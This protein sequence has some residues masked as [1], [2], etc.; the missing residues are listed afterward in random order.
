MS[1]LYSRGRLITLF[2]VFCI[3]ATW[4]FVVIA[5]PSFG[6]GDGSTAAALADSRAG[7]I[8]LAGYLAGTLALVAGVLPRLPARVIAL[9]PLA[10]VANAAVGQV[11]GSIGIPLYLDSVGTVLIAALTGPA[12]GLTTGAVSSVAWGLVNPT[13]LPFAAVSAATGAM[14]GLAVERGA[15]KSP[16][17]MV[18]AGAVIGIVSGMLAAP[19]AAFVYGGTSGVGTGALV[20]VF[21]EVTGS[22]I[23]SVTLQ[24]AVSDPADK[25]AVLFIVWATLKALPTRALSRDASAASYRPGA[26]PATDRL[27]RFT[28]PVPAE[29]GG[30]PALTVS[31]RGSLRPLAVLA[32]AAIAWGVVFTA[33]S[34][35]VSLL[36]VAVALVVC[37][38]ASRRLHLAAASVAVS[39]P[40]ALSVAI[41]HAP[42]GDH[43]IG[44]GV[45][46]DGLMTA[47]GLSARC[48]ALASCVL[49]ASACIRPA[50]LAKSIERV[51]GTSPAGTSPTARRLAYLAGVAI[52]VIPQTGR[53]VAV[54]RDAN[55]L[56]GVRAN[57]RTIVPHFA[58]PVMSRLLGSGAQRGRALAA[59]GFDDSAAVSSSHASASRPGAPIQHIV[60]GP[61]T[62]KEDYADHLAREYG[63]V[64]V[65]GPQPDAH[66][67]L[68]RDTVEEELALPLEYRGV[69]AAIIDHCVRETTHLLGLSEHLGADPTTLSGGQTRRLAIGAVGISRPDVLVVCDPTVGLDPQARKQVAEYLQALA[70]AHTAVI[71]VGYESD[72]LLGGRVIEHDSMGRRDAA[73]RSA[74][75]PAP[76]AP[77]GATTELGPVIATR[78]RKDGRTAAFR[79]G[80]VS[81]PVRTGG[82]TWLRGPNGAGKTTVLRCLAG[83][84][85][86]D[87][88]GAPYLRDEWDV[89]MALQSADDQL[90]E[91]R[92]ADV[93]F[94]GM[95][96]RLDIDACAHPLDL[97]E[98][99]QKL[100]NVAAELDG[101]SRGQRGS[102][103]RLVLLDEPDAGLAP[104]HRQALHAEI[105]RALQNGA[106]MIL[107]CHDDRFAA[108]VREY[109]T[110]TEVKLADR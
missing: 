88:E 71:T 11:V 73:D 95:L 104:R 81:I 21:Q 96:R 29:D 12:A 45:T 82:V 6:E 47:A 35:W 22:L 24:S 55:Q 27:Q 101:A 85:A 84:D 23:S 86:G 87:T 15:F 49:A 90:I 77:V 26:N 7:L 75:L 80:P 31:R 13:A 67:S 36:V 57:V 98:S 106:A 94:A 42:H 10:V 52:Q 70:D 65:V 60:L 34:T 93:A 69:D 97:S 89:A 46:S 33:N 43:P 66:V 59:I 25:I 50:E 9:I 100:L 110:V 40:V 107:T 108:A 78:G 109:A 103:F 19:V 28:E 18:S 20:S 76:V 32:L 74:A 51:A 99:A 44:W 4:V 53:Q 2:G 5:R 48:W 3:A 79:V 83:L 8:T 58:V 91:P 1:L 54:V 63:T 37:V 64:A 68:L 16:W 72:P 105:A 41:I 14:A 30:A 92:C 102:G 56:R 38:A 39:L 62:V 17:R 61:D